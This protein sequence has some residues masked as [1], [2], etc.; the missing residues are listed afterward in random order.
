VVGL[1]RAVK[2]V[3]RNAFDNAEPYEREF[4]G[5][6]HYLPISLNHPGL[7]R[8]LHVGR[9]DAGGYF[10]S[11]MELADDE[12]SGQQINPD[13]YQPRNLA[14]EITRK[15]RIPAAD[16]VRIFAALADALD[17]LHQQQLIHR[18]IKPSNI[19]LVG[20]APKLADIGL[21]TSVAASGQAVTQLGTEGYIAPEGPGSPTA[22]VY[23]LGKVLYE[24]CMGRDR[25]L[26]PEFP[27]TWL[28]RPDHALLVELNK[29]LGKACMTDCRLRYTSAA[30]MQADLVRLQHLGAGASPAAASQGPA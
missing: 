14:R 6:Q 30:Q 8:V 28:G 12:V 26:F 1:Y 3:Y 9:N 13:T 5:I 16:C 18:D 29:I 17:Y 11:I 7:V 2:I 27:T 22:D 19:I 24:A 25:E 10:Y 21:V 20:G 23:S 15:G 4:R